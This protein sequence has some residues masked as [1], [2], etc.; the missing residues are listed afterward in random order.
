MWRIKHG[1]Q[2]GTKSNGKAVLLQHALICSGHNFLSNTEDKAL[3]FVLANQGFDVWIGNNRGNFFSRK[4]A[5]LDPDKDASFWDFS[6]EEMGLSDLSAEV[7][8]IRISTGVRKIGYVGHSEGTIQMFFSLALQES[9]WQE[10]IY[11][12]AALAPVARTGHL[13]SGILQ[14][15]AKAHLGTL[16]RDLGVTEFAARDWLTSDALGLLCSSI[17]LVCEIGLR[18]GSDTNPSED[19]LERA[20][21]ALAYTPAGTSAKNMEH[22]EQLTTSGQF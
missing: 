13:G 10:R 19:D 12:F 21:V 16:L 11:A 14:L 15:A 3:A 1:N 7:E 17:P 20:A 2:N 8:Y 5:T 9:Y 6:F 18:L 4:H 22:W